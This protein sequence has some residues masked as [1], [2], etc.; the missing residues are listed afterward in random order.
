MV[1]QRYG[2]DRVRCLAIPMSPSP[3]LQDESVVD[4]NSVLERYNL[5][6]GYFFYPAQ[7]WSHKNHARI[8]EALVLLRE[9]RINLRLV[10]VGSDKG[11]RE[12]IENLVARY[13]LNDQVRFL[14]FVPA[15]H[16]RGLYEGC[17]AVIM[18]TYF[19]PTNLPVL[20]AWMIGKPVVYSA[21]LKEQAGDAAILVNPDDAA[22]LAA[23]MK[24][25]TDPA[26]SSSLVKRGTS[27]LHQIALQRNQSETELAKRL[28]QFEIRRRCWA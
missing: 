10:L 8:L 18:P 9:K 23:A 1:S 16:M 27:R 28:L 21:H 24:A 6:E 25:C 14:G 12:H 13:L 5:E 3:F 7:F 19:G 15:E 11:N 2:I 20:E 22:E 17:A 26:V 4:K